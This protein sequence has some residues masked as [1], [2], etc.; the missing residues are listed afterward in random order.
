MFLL[1]QQKSADGNK[2]NLRKANLKIDEIKYFV[3][4]QASSIV[5]RTI[6][7]KLESKMIYFIMILKIMGIPL[8]NNS[9]CSY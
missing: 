5:L 9:Y 8:I 2:N 6:K 7:D 1:L 4:H 3:Y